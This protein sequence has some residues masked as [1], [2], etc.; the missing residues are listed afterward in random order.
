MQKGLLSEIN[1]LLTGMDAPESQEYTAD[2]MTLKKEK[3]EKRERER[4]KKE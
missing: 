1:D 2:M 4:K 3:K